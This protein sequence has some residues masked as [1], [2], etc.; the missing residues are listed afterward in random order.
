MTYVVRLG[1]KRLWPS[2]WSLKCLLCI[3][4][5]KA[6]VA[7]V[8]FTAK[9]GDSNQN[10]PV[11]CRK[12]VCGTRSMRLFP[13]GVRGFETGSLYIGLAALELKI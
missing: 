13:S 11:K 5:R 9:L 4:C 8:L 7:S 10:N 1:G 3:R 2:R 12:C 6:G